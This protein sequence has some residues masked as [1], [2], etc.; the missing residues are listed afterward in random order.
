MTGR[1]RSRA[2]TPSGRALP[3][4]E[5]TKASPWVPYEDVLLQGLRDSEEA[6]AYLKAALEDGDEAVL[7]LAL[8]QVEKA[9]RLVR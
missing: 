1:Y 2:N 5:R 4:K 3:R 7:T 6:L 9:R 8:R